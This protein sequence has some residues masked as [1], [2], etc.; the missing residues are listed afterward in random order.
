MKSL[1][2]RVDGDPQPGGSKRAFRSASTHKIVVLDDCKRNAA[3]R[4]H[5]AWTAKSAFHAAGYDRPFTGP[6][7][8]HIRFVKPRPKSH[9]ASRT[10]GGALKLA[11]PLQHLSAPDS[12]KLFRACEDALAG[13]L[14]VNDA[15]VIEQSATKCWGKDGCAEITVQ[16][17]ADET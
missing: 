12:S 1:T 13:I 15:Q 8:L 16:C 14:F 4:E 17:L 3:W 9:Y 7:A 2:F 10:V 11:A 5:V 6:V